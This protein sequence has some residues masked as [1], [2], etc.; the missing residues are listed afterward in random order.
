MLGEPFKF[1][2]VCLSM[3]VLPREWYWGFFFQFCDIKN[4]ANF[5]KILGKL[6]KFAM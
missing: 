5:S 2:W 6:V 1:I 4:L 3:K